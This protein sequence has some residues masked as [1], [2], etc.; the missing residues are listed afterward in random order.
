MRAEVV[1]LKTAVNK[2]EDAAS[3]AKKESEGIKKATP[4][5][6]DDVKD[7]KAK[8]KAAED[9]LVAV[10]VELQKA[11]KDL[12]A[13]RKSAEEAKKAA[14][15]AKAHAAELEAEVK[16]L[17]EQL[18]SAEDELVGLRK[19]LSKV[20]SEVEGLKLRGKKLE[21]DVSTRD[22]RVAELEKKVADLQALLEAR[23]ASD[24]SANLQVELEAL[25]VRCQAAED[26]SHT[27]KMAV[28][29]AQALA[30]I[31]KTKAETL[32]KQ[33]TESQETIVSLRQRVAELEKADKEVSSDCLCGTRA[34]VCL[35]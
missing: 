30:S 8:L 22:A 25:R 12:E 16:R 33:L 29:E 11:S 31:A 7:L 26:A 14:E 3:K 13:A 27:H 6:D 9:K 34:R 1:S 5:S 15:A 35:W 21:D 32:G 23:S 4:V 10:S 17:R 28:T 19:E 18:S 2:A 24:K 20:Q